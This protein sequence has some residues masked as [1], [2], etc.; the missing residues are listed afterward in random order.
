[1]INQYTATHLPQMFIILLICCIAI[2]RELIKKAKNR[3]Y[4][5]Q[6]NRYDYRKKQ[7]QKHTKW[8]KMAEK[9]RKQNLKMMKENNFD[10]KPLTLEETKNLK[11]HDYLEACWKELNK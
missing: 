11:Y 1:M 9:G 10:T 2:I 7:R 4:I 3:K 6:F 5:K 8:H